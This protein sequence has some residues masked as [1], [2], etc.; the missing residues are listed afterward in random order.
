M[1]LW[2]RSSQPNGRPPGSS[3]FE[4]ENGVFDFP[5]EKFDI[6]LKHELFECDLKLDPLL[7]W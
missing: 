6:V 4:R 2:S 5:K 3:G 7:M 1:Q